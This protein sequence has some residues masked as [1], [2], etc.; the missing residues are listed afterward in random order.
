MDITLRAATLDDV[1]LIDDMHVKSRRVTYRGHVSD[2]YL[3]VTMPA[4]SLAE[5]QAKLPP[6][7]AAG[8]CV[9]I[10]EDAGEAVGFVTSQAVDERGVVYVNNLHA[11]PERKGRGIGTALLAEVARRARDRGARAMQLHVLETNAAAIAFY[12]A[13]GW[14]RL[15]REEHVWAGETVGALLYERALT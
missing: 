5:W 14:R 13:R 12:E 2:H 10:A 1:A 11:M 3:D 8:G 15:L 7:L 6:L 9:R 4:A